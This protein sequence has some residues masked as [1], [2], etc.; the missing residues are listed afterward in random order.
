MNNTFPLMAP[1]VEVSAKDVFGVDF[2]DY[3]DGVATDRFED[4]LLVGGE[5]GQPD[6]TVFAA[7]RSFNIILTQ[8]K[9]VK[10]RA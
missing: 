3:F 10:G 9:I 2:G 6:M 8:L 7:Q 4:Q 1:D 5:G